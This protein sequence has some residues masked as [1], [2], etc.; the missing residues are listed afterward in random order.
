MPHDEYSGW[1]L[2]LSERPEGWKEDLRAYRIMQ[3]FGT[4]V[5]PAEVFPAL[6][7]IVA[8]RAKNLGD[9]FKKSSLFQKLLTAKGGEKPGFMNE[10]SS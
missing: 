7:P 10:D 1:L 2:Y 5:K 3:A 9:S 6:Q 8:P 4:K